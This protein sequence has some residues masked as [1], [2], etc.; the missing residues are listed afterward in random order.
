[1]DIF[2]SP[3]GIQMLIRLSIALGLGALIGLERVLAH[4]TAG[5]RTY[6]L[7]SMGSA[8]FVIISQVITAAAGGNAGDPLRIASQI[9]VGVGF[10]GAGLIIFKDSHLQGL[11]TASALWVAAG[12]G[13][14]AGFGLHELAVIVTVLTLFTF[15]VLWYV[16][17]LFRK[18]WER[19]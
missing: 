7:V 3:D 14:A 5:V 8:L 16:E 11:T 9:V 13:M 19:K 10:L 15:T 6:A 12:I 17:S 4:K 18:W 1:M 2:L